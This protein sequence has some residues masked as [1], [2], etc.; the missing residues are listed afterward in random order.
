MV[1]PQV[2]I[3]INHKNYVIYFHVLSLSD[4]LDILVLNVILIFM[5]KLEFLL[6]FLLLELIF[7]PKL[8]ELQGQ[9][10]VVMANQVQIMFFYNL[11]KHQIYIFYSKNHHRLLKKYLFFC[12]YHRNNLH[13]HEFSKLSRI[14][15]AI[16]YKPIFLMF[17][18]M[19]I[20]ILSTSQF[21]PV[22]FFIPLQNLYFF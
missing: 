9:Q 17:T 13:S 7:R 2:F 21:L 20:L 10:G 6:S 16:N 12:K 1:F 4:V 5:V 15:D 11:Y 18:F 19:I 14:M 8:E 3:C 22:F